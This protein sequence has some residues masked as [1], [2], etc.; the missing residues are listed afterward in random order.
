MLT[1]ADARER[2]LHPAMDG[3]ALGMQQDRLIHNPSEDR[4]SVLEHLM[5]AAELLPAGHPA[6]REIGAAIGLLGALVQSNRREGRQWRTVI[7]PCDEL[8]RSL[9]T[10]PAAA[11]A[12]R[13]NYR[14]FCKQARPHLRVIAHNLT[15]E[16]RKDTARE[17]L[18][19]LIADVPAARLLSV[20]V[21]HELDGNVNRPTLFTALTEYVN[22]QQQ[23]VVA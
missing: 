6:R 2:L 16:Q 15:S 4:D 7:G 8:V 10:T 13:F 22:Q 3:L 19:A 20:S 11:A 17:Q 18:A 9:H 14:E 1:A 23:G 5:H 21:R 12:P